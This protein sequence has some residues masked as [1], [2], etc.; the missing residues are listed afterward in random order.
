MDQEH[1]QALLIDHQP[2][3]LRL[4]YEPLCLLHTL[5][6]VRGDRIKSGDVSSEFPESSAPKCYRA[7]VDA[8]AYICAYQKKPG[9]V[10]TAALE[11]APDAIVILLAAN[12]GIDMTVLALL[13]KVRVILL[14]IVENSAVQLDT[15]EGRG[16]MKILTDYVLSLNTPKIFE[17]YQQV[18]KSV[19][20]VVGQLN[21]EPGLKG[22]FEN[23]SCVWK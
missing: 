7:F 18:N 6:E 20:S 3:K 14:W 12:D 8:I 5:S 15:K 13:E 10:T 19:S 22:M 9:Y 23:S 1:P 2:R 21:A 4:L 16:I 17:Y 11:E